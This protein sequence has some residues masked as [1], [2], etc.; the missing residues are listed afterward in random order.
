MDAQKYL[1]DFPI[2]PNI[3]VKLLTLSTENSNFQDLEDLVK[4]DPGLTSKVLQVANSAFY[5]QKGEVDTLKRAISV[6]GFTTLRSMLTLIVASRAMKALGSNRF[7]KIYWKQA[8]STAFTAK[9][10]ASYQQDR[11]YEELAFIGGLLHNIGE[12]AIFRKEGDE[13][14]Q[15]LEQFRGR[16]EELFN[17][18]KEMWQT[19]HREIGGQI[20]Q[21]WNFPMLY[22]DIALQHLSISINSPYKNIITLISLG[23]LITLVLDDIR[24][25]ESLLDS[26]CKL[27]GLSEEGRLFFLSGNYKV[28]LEADPLFEEY[29]RLF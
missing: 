3:A 16:E 23:Y 8:L 14:S 13:Y 27:A 12:I 5:A 17:R 20:L 28:N 26:F 18:E 11:E 2:I 22:Q 29:Q 6:V 1:K 25:E 24:V 19:D 4:L 7:Y 21:S 9:A 15:V 10:L